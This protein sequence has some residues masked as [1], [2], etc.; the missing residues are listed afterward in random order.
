VSHSEVD[1]YAARAT[2]A[3]QVPTKESEEVCP[4]PTRQEGLFG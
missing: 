2:E 1:H 4:T 3:R